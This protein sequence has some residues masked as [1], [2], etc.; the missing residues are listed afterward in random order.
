[1]SARDLTAKYGNKNRNNLINAAIRAELTA[2][3]EA[4]EALNE[5][6]MID[7]REQTKSTGRA[8]EHARAII[9][10]MAAE[11]RRRYGLEA[12]PDDQDTGG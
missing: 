8:V 6:R 7:D 11:I 1:M 3:P 4:L 12:K 2:G 9:D 10:A 5:L